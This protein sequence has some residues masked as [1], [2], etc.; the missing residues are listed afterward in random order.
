LLSHQPRPT[1]DGPGPS[2]LTALA[3]ALAVSIAE[4]AERGEVA[5]DDPLA[6]AHLLV[7]SLA[8]TVGHQIVFGGELDADRIAAEAKR[9]TRRAL[10]LPPVTH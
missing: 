5:V 6:T 10:A 2:G 8:S 9:L 1:A 4:A 7:H 3:D